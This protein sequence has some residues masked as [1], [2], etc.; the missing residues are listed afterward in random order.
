MK[1]YNTF[2]KT[3]ETFQPKTSGEVSVYAC[4]PTVYSF[5]HIGNFRSFLTADLIVRFFKFSGVTVNYVSNV[6]DV[7]HLTVDDIADIS[8]DDKMSKAF[9]SQSEFH[10]IF[11]L[12]R[13]FTDS[14]LHDWAALNLSEPN[15]RPRATE[16][17]A[18]QLDLIEKLE[19]LG[20]A[21]ETDMGVYFDVSKFPKYG[22][23]SGNLSEA[24][25]NGQR[26]VVTDSQKRSERDFA[27]WKKDN[28][29]LMKWYSKYGWG[30][31]GWHI[32][33]SAMAMK[34]LGSSF[35]IH[36]GGEDNIFPHHECEIAQS[37][38][39]SGETFANYW[40]HTRHLRVNGERMAKSRGNFKT[41][42]DIFDSGATPMAL[43]YA[44]T[45]G[46]Y[47]EPLNLTDEALLA[48]QKV[49]D[50]LSKIYTKAT[51]KFGVTGDCQ[52]AD[53]DFQDMLLKSVEGMYEAVSDDLN[54][55]I[56]YSILNKT[57]KHIA[58]TDLTSINSKSVIE[59]LSDVE[60]LL[61][62]K[63]E[64]TEVTGKPSPNDDI[65]EDLNNLRQE[66]RSK[67]NFEGSDA[68]RDILSQHGL[69]TKDKK[70]SE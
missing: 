30:Y 12:A 49:I 41:V 10:N 59:W 48:G 14:F 58:A 34:Y 47:R 43:R 29:H 19:K 36:T 40:V 51:E 22:R 11:D 33:C 6:T 13:F 21:Y 38:A 23:L 65:I 4:G 3:T 67:K 2:S 27:L 69:V 32:E 35:D 7:G 25:L 28:N 31:P 63:V 68:I 46:K 8:G 57:A 52:K 53:K 60:K 42:K 61:G 45:A 62:L 50:R 20:F 56:A 55:P 37:E 15:V 18:E 16:H 66:L 54:T 9:K 24:A 5:A 44:L 70:T 64:M 26:D 17:V 39:V 1:I